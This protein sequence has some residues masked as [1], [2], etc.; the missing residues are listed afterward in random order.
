MHKMTQIKFNPWIGNNYSHAPFGKRVLVLG[1]SHYQW[2]HDKPIN[3]LTTITNDVIN[4]QLT[5]DC[6]KSFW[7]HIAVT[8]L[9][10]LPSTEEKREFW[11]S[12]AF[13]NYVSSVDILR[14]WLKPLEA[15]EVEGQTEKK[16]LEPLSQQASS[17]SPS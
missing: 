7:T 12:I 15:V 10:K 2:E 5:G 4:E 11:N 1:E 13:Y 9:N 6:T 3:N 17:R 8:F 16:S 14:R